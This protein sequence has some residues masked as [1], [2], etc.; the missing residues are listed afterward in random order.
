MK[1]AITVVLIILLGF[2][3][4]VSAESLFGDDGYWPTQEEYEA[5]M[6]IV[7]RYHQRQQQL[8]GEAESDATTSADQDDAS[9]IPDDREEEPAVSVRAVSSPPVTVF[10]NGE[11][12]GSSVTA[13]T[14]DGVNGSVWIGYPDLTNQEQSGRLVFTENLYKFREGS[15]FCGFEFVHD[16]D[17]DTLTLQSVCDSTDPPNPIV[18]FKRDSGPIMLERS[19]GIGGSYFDGSAGGGYLPVM[20]LGN[21]DLTCNAVCGNH[22]M[23]CQYAVDMTRDFHSDKKGTSRICSGF[24][25]YYCTKP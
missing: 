18:A 13:I 4:G 12:E 5:A 10:G 21:N 1:K 11:I 6:V 20:F 24:K 23:T 2:V 8:R 16:G 17:A 19:V 22:L 15:G 14:A 7:H 3:G 9:F 25:G